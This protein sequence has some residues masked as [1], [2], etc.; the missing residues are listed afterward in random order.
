MPAVALT[1][2]AS[3][4]KTVNWQVPLTPTMAQQLRERAEIEGRTAPAIVRRLISSYLES[5]G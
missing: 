3:E 1:Q 4:K 5:A 2:K